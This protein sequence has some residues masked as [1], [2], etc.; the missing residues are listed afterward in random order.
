MYGHD[1]NG[2]IVPVNGTPPR[3][4]PTRDLLPDGPSRR[5]GAS[6]GCARMGEAE[7]A[8]PA[9]DRGAARGEREGRRRPADVPGL[10][11]SL[12]GGLTL[13]LGEA[14]LPDRSRPAR[15]RSSGSWSFIGRPLNHGTCRQMARQ[16][17]RRQTVRADIGTPGIASHSRWVAGRRWR[18][19]QPAMIA[20]T[21][22]LSASSRCAVTTIRTAP[23]AWPASTE[24]LGPA[25]TGRVYLGPWWGSRSTKVRWG[26][27]LHWARTVRDKSQIN[28][29]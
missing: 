11:V 19:Y 20:S 3:E 22:L 12:L 16:P 4:A 6:D 15:S 28:A 13:R 24:S 1:R 10:E 2:R 25:A 8:D 14:N 7:P 23:R 17:Q 18:S 27:E 29:I 9:V 21:F 5:E 26:I